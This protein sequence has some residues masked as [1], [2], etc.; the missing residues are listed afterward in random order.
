MT[1]LLSRGS[2]EHAGEPENSVGET[3]GVPLPGMAG[4]GEGTHLLHAAHTTSPFR[5]PGH[6]GAGTTS[7]IAAATT[8]L[9]DYTGKP[10]EMSR[11]CGDRMEK[12]Q[13]ARLFRVDRSWN[14]PFHAGMENPPAKGARRVMRGTKSRPA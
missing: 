10:K 7:Q 12:S 5:H 14:M 11:D 4:E 3:T 9:A 6:H 2:A 8:F 1:G 13:R